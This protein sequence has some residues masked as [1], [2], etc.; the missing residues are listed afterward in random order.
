[1]LWNASCKKNRFAHVFFQSALAIFLLKRAQVICWLRVLKKFRHLPYNYF[2]SFPFC[3]EKI[4]LLCLSGFS[5]G[6]AAAFLLAFLSA[7]LSLLLPLPDSVASSSARPSGSPRPELFGIIHRFPGIHWLRGSA[8]SF[9]TS[10]GSLL[11]IWAPW[12]LVIL[13]L[14][15]L[16]LVDLGISSLLVILGVPSPK[17]RSLLRISSIWASISPSCSW[18]F[19]CLSGWSVKSYLHSILTHAPCSRL[20]SRQNQ[21]V[22]G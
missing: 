6:L 16:I 8:F 17:P 4:L 15:W 2:F 18:S 13:G 19:F 3:S 22:Q 7:F 1:M 21:E 9:W 10:I 14:H 12:L 20:H 5:F 11:S